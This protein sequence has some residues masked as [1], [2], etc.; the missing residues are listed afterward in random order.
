MLRWKRRSRRA[1]RA[2]G[3][4]QLA[5]HDH[6]F[7]D[8]IHERIELLGVHAH[9]GSAELLALPFSGRRQ[10]SAEQV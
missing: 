4:D 8:D 2:G 10:P 5:L 9:R 6:E 1:E 7:A 3:F